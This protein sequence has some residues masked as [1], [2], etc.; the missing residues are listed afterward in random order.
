MEKTINEVFRNRVKK[1]GDKLCVEK[2]LKG[3]WETATWNEYYDRSRKVGL[4]LYDL[5]VRKGEMVAILS[6]NR[7]EWIYTDMG[8]LGIGG[9][10]IPIYA[11]V[12]Q[13]EVEYIINNSGSKV[14]VVENKDQLEKVNLIKSKCPSLQKIAVIDTTGCT[15]DGK[16]TISFAAL[17]EL[18]SKKHNADPALFEKLADQ[19]GPD[20]MLTFQ[21]TSGT[22][23]LP[24]GAIHTHG[25]IMAEL[26]ALDASRPPYGYE[27]DN[28]VGFLPL[29]HIFERVPVH[30][31]VMFKG[32]TKAYVESMETAVVDIKEKQ[33]TILFA[34]PRVLEKIYQKML[35]TI[36]EKPPVV[37]KLFAW[38]QVVG[39]N[40]S[41]YKEENKSVPLGLRIKHKIAYALIFKKLQE[42]LGGR[43]RWMCAAG[44]PIAREIVNFFNGAGIFVMEGYGLSE[45]GGGATLSNLNDFKPGSVGRPLQNTDLKIAADGEILIKGPMM[46]KGYW[47]LEAET[48]NAFNSDGYFMTG[49]IGKIDEKGFLFITD[50]KKDLIITSGGKNIAP[51]KIETML[52]ENPLFA[53]AVV[54]GERKN[55]LTLLLNLDYDIAAQ[56]AKANGIE[57]GNSRDLAKNAEF[58]KV[59]DNFINE[60]NAKLAKYETVKKY[61]ILEKDFTQEGGELT[62]SLKVKRNVV[63]AKYSAVID[64]MYVGEK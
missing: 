62:V 3:K 1:Y 6:Q 11:T 28:V 29:S 63:H 57:F 10:V 50:R 49:D 38:A 41:K 13:D 9:V 14:I 37:Q 33:P 21:Y 48:K 55:Y 36:R 25:T 47:K 12:K 52:K 45:V 20:D 43:L 23:G 31:Y 59:I 53:Q 22:T 4:G 64:E 17:M 18:G 58:L 19:V 16:N 24:K 32:I 60:V 26:H 35:H 61:K 2:K 34:V 15:I 56:I 46:F 39:D 30:F 8:T 27:T 42:A 44:A 5:G 7:L 40:V 51:Q 54:I